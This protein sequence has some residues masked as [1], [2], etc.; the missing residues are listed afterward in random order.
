MKD[1]NNV[2]QRFNH[3]FESKGWP[4][5][6]M[7]AVSTL[8]HGTGEPELDATRWM[9]AL[10]S[11]NIPIMS[12]QSGKTVLEFA[13][14]FFAQPNQNPEE[15][16]STLRAFSHMAGIELA[17]QEWKPE[18][19][20]AYILM[21]LAGMSLKEAKKDAKA[22]EILSGCMY[23]DKSKSAEEFFV[24]ALK[25]EKELPAFAAYV[26]RMHGSTIIR[27]LRNN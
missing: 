17:S 25:M 27:M 18:D 1:V 26:A 2:Q 14:F 12:V 21:R 19:I 7:V 15:L 8:P 11:P 23:L 13:E 20:L 9:L 6:I 4:L 5:C 10:N 24:A 3:F 16:Y 22:L